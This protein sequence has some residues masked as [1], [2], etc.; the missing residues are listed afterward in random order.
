MFQLVKFNN[1]SLNSYIFQT[2][3]SLLV[4]GVVVFKNDLA[5]LDDHI[6]RILKIYQQV[7]SAKKSKKETQPNTSQDSEHDLICDIYFRIQCS[8]ETSYELFNV[9][10]LCRITIHT[11]LILMEHF[12][13]LVSGE[14]KQLFGCLA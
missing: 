14:Q 13:G 10:Y 12:C 5:K 6:V 2:S 7:I 8:I 1:N 4:H 3:N 9:R 11:S